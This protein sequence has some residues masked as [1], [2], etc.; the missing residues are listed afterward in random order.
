MRHTN[1]EFASLTGNRGNNF[2]TVNYCE[3][4]QKKLECQ[5]F[6]IQRCPNESQIHLS[7][8]SRLAFK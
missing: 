1:E 3:K 6:Q 5:R 4:V 8:M 7:N 2:K